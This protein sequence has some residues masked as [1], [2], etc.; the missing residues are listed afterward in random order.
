FTMASRSDKDA[1]TA[2]L[3]KAASTNSNNVHIVPSQDGWSV[4]REGAVRSTAVRATRDE[5]LKAA[6]ELKSAER[7]II[8]NPDGT[9]AKNVPGK[10]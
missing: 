5:A 7:I 3:R 2:K 9:I 8:H 10:K 4:K 1:L 6:K